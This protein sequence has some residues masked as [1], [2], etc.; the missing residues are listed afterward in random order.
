MKHP[1]SQIA[2]LPYNRQRP[3]LT[4]QTSMLQLSDFHA[5]ARMQTWPKQKHLS[6]RL[7]L[8]DDSMCMAASGAAQMFA[9]ASQTHAIR[10]NP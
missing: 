10:F 6:P 3:S 8:I 4:A 7:W 5:Q 1:S 2:I 9:L